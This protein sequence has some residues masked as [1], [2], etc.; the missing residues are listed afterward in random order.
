MANHVGWHMQGFDAR[1]RNPKLM[2]DNH[3]DLFMH[4]RAVSDDGQVTM[5][6]C[7]GQVFFW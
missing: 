5:D 3:N 7:S 4:R 6:G 2:M 1:N